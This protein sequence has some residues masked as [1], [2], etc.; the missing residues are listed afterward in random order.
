MS[1]VTFIAKFFVW[2]FV[3]RI[4]KKIIMWFLI[5]SI[6]MV[7]LYKF[8][9]VPYT[10]FMFQRCLVQK[11]NGED[12]KLIKE[13]VS[14]D[15]I[16][17][18]VELAVVCAEDQNYLK[19]NGFDFG[20]IKKAI[21]YNEKMEAKGKSKRRGASTIS[22]QTAKNV[23]LW[24][25][26]S[27]IRKGFEV[28]FTF[29]IETLWSKERIMEVYLNVIELGN[30][31][32]GVEAASQ[33]YL[34]KSAARLTASD[35]ALIAVVLPNPRKFSIA[36]PSAYTRKRQSWCL[37]QMRYWGMKLDYDKNYDSSKNTDNEE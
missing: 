29:L 26:R 28:Y 36:N 34:K 27:W 12:M 8:L 3:F 25:G 24:H 37:R 31:V 7:L 2:S 23:F 6:G 33:E 22:Q 32:Y 5:I 10:F 17:N 21:D 30:G 1:V 4:L 9:P 20:A 19:H 15:E 11:S 18:Y 13:W 35:A 16:S 14:K